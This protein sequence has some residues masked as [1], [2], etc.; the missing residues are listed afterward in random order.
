MTLL[1]FLKI[2]PVIS[3]TENTAIQAGHTWVDGEL[4]SGRPNFEKIMK[5]PY[6]SISEKEK[7]FIEEKVNQVCAMTDDEVVYKDGDLSSA[8]W[9]YLKKERF[10][11]LIIPEEYG[12]LGFS[13]IAHSEVIQKLASRSI[14]LSITV[15]VPNS[16]GPAELLIHYGTKSQKDFYLPR[17]A[18]GAEIPCFGLTEPGAGSD[19]GAMIS[20]GIIFRSSADGKLYVKLNWKKRYITLGAVAT[21]LG[22]AVK[23]Y[24]P[25]NLLGKGEEPGITCILVPSQTNGVILGRRHDPLG[26]PFYNC[27]IEGVDVV[28]SIDQIIGGADG[29][30]QGWRMLMECLAAG[31][32]ISLPASSTG[33][34]KRV[35][36]VTGAYAAV[37]KQFGI[38][39]GQFEGISETLGR[40]GAFT[41]LLEACRK[42]TAG[43]VDGG[44][45]PAV[46]SAIIKYHSTEIARKVIN[47]AMD[48]CGGAGISKGP[49]NLLANG[50]TAAPIAITVEGAN[51]LTRTMIIFG[52]GAIRCHPFAYKEITALGQD[53]VKNF[54]RAFTGH[55]GHIVRNA[56]SAV[57]LSLT[58]GRIVQVPFSTSCTRYYQ[59]LTWVSAS[60]AFLSD[61]SMGLFGGKLKFLESLT[62]RFADILSWMYLITAALRRFHEEGEKE[63]HR[64]MIDYVCQYGF[65]EIQKAFQGIYQNINLPFLGKFIKFTFGSWSQVN[66]LSSLPSDKT[67]HEIA[68][69]LIVPGDVRN[70][71]T[72]GMYLPK[73]PE[74]LA[75]LD[76]ALELAY[77]SDQVFRKIHRA[78]K[79]GILKK[80]KK[81]LIQEAFEQNVI[82]I[83]EKN[84]LQAA[85]AAAIVAIQVDSFALQDYGSGITNAYEK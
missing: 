51:I 21:V 43:A 34:A 33:G 54:D 73:N 17:L 50:Y 20:S 37:R 71:L 60:F 64:P 59:K 77:Q 69:L 1:K 85:E 82:S 48:I 45:K 52:Q 38:S 2:M 47:D 3:E 78:I 41:Y 26:V 27:P 16:L 13:A 40:M 29:A 57:L 84:L 74:P 80:N 49:K 62:G 18:I 72:Q 53:D 24:D 83:E 28:V 75:E 35:L 8:V 6:S 19:A 15:M 32:A 79:Q 9:E 39:I 12:G 58:R 42:Y 14:P 4:F 22:L 65:F 76:S 66:S 11:G 23:L 5:E 70:D 44:L 7:K 25:E 10:F 67:V 55:I 31:R 81:N 68:K 61:L 63:S 36:R 46:I 56:T 30:G